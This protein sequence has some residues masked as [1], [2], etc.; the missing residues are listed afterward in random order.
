MADGRDKVEVMGCDAKIAKS[1]WE[2]RLKETEAKNKQEE[3]R[4]QKSALKSINEEWA[5]RLEQRMGMQKYGSQKKME[6]SA[7]VD[8]VPEIDS[9]NAFANKTPLLPSPGL[10]PSSGGSETGQET[11]SSNPFAK[12]TPLQP[13]PG[14][15]PSS[16][17]SG[18]G[19]SGK[20]GPVRSS[21][22]SSSSM[23]KDKKKLPNKSLVK[24]QLLASIDKT[25]PSTM[26]WS[27][28]W[29]YSKP[30]PKPEEG[31]EV[32]STWGQCWRLAVQQ[33][34]SE[35][36]KPWPNGP[37]LVDHHDLSLWKNGI[38]R[39]IETHGLDL[40]LSTDEWQMSWK[41]SQRQTGQAGKSASS[42]KGSDDPKYGMFSSLEETQHQNEA[43]CSSEWSDSWKATK[44]REEGQHAPPTEPTNGPIESHVDKKPKNGL[45]SSSWKFM[46]RQLH[47]K[48]KQS[49]SVQNCNLAEWD[50]SWRA[51]VTVTNGLK[52]AAN[53]PSPMQHQK[54]IHDV[55]DNEED[56][57]H[58]VII[59]MSVSR[60]SKYRNR[61]KSLLCDK[62][63]PLPEWESSWKMTKND[64]E[65]S[66]ELKKVLM[67]APAK[68]QVEKE[69]KPKEQ[70][71]LTEKKDPR[72]EQLR[73]EVI[74][75]PRMQFAVSE[76]HLHH[77]RPSLTQWM[78]A[79]RQPV[80]HTEHLDEQ[81]L[82]HIGT[83]ASMVI[84]HWRGKLPLEKAKAKMSRSFDSHIFRER[85][86]EKHWS[87]SWKA[88]CLLSS[89]SGTTEQGTDS[90]MH[91]QSVAPVTEQA[92]EWGMPFRI[93][94]PMPRVDKPW[95]ECS[96]NPSRHMVLF[97]RGTRSRRQKLFVAMCKDHTEHKYFAQYFKVWGKSYSFL[98]GPSGQAADKSSRSDSKQQ[99][100]P[101]VLMTRNINMKYQYLYVKINQE[102]PDGKKWAGGHLLCKTQP[103]PK[104]SS[105]PLKK[106][107]AEEAD[108]AE[109]TKFFEEWSES[110]RYVVRPQSLKK[111]APAKNLSG[112][113]DSWKFLLPPYP[114]QNGPMRK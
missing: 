67:A 8:V 29:K 104:K 66:E 98:M 9:S 58:K 2:S 102:K 32:A 43:M 30:L 25:Q 13:P 52:K 103:R 27:K 49:S 35:A 4:K 91:E 33:P 69:E 85:Y 28:S 47:Y 74:Y 5:Q 81:L 22:L 19:G 31:E 92:S 88:T 3:M 75:Q 94:N 112:W 107:A 86:P 60:E 71:S 99:D 72:Y 54:D 56:P 55:H 100:D 78:D 37:N 45:P 21:S 114:T 65:P 57:L 64:S 62:P 59:D 48:S 73:H 80:F 18:T 26:V 82:E 44:P 68:T 16:R 105:A 36:V 83:E 1:L 108:T 14:F 20:G 38:H 46:N 79:W 11:D 97:A 90:H 106:A 12:K 95:V 6:R 109:D 96:P 34:Y 7:T 63:E 17:G 113:G 111:Q 51:A 39:M 70:C 61:L 24:L 40:D 76:S 50:K 41:D 10:K 110:W 89:S 42:Q 15:K 53:D 84:G 87:E 101:W 93:A 23:S 77:D